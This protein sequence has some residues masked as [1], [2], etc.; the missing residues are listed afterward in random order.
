MPKK[1]AADDG[2]PKRVILGRPGNHVSVGI[3]GTSK[4]TIA[5]QRGIDFAVA[6]ARA[7]WPT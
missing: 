2:V 3:V 6:G 7:R 5:T 4:R 1:K